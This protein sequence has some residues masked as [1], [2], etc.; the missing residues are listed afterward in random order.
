VVVRAANLRHW[1]HR[2]P[3]GCAGWITARAMADPRLAQGIVEQA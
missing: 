2:Q 1:Q 3:I